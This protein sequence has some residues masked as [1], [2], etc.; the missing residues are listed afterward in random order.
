MHVI[1]AS[2]LPRIKAAQTK[3]ENLAQKALAADIAV[4]AATV[5]LEQA[6]AAANRVRAAL[7]DARATA[8]AAPGV[9]HIGIFG[10]AVV[11]PLCGGADG[12]VVTPASA[13]TCP[14][15]LAKWRG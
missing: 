10:E 8:S 14:A 12:A 2:Q 5:K 13:A 6:K 15:C 9:L 1:K 11:R 3:C 4:Q 7:E